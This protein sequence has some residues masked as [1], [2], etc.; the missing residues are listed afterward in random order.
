MARAASRQVR[1]QAA[2]ILRRLIDTVERG[3]LEAP[4]WFLERLRGAA[5]ALEQD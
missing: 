5:M 1:H 2:V 3:E 4:A